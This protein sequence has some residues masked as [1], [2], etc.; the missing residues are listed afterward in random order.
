MARNERN[1]KS[2]KNLKFW[3]FQDPVLGPRVIPNLEKPLEG[4][5][6]L[7]SETKFHID[8]DTQKVFVNDNVDVGQVI[9]YRYVS[10]E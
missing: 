8:L 3:R 2:E 10:S 1:I 4:K 7:P 9:V 6:E 5:V